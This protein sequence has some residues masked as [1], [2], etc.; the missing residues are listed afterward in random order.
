MAAGGLPDD[1]VFIGGGS[2]IENKRA[3]IG[4]TGIGGRGM[5]VQRVRREFTAVGEGKDVGGSEGEKPDATGHDEVFH[6][7][8]GA[9]VR[10]Y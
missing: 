6:G 7:M 2:G 3:G 5:S 4:M 8:G 9:F 10:M 1:P